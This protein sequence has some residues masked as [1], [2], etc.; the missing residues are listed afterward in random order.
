MADDPAAQTLDRYDVLMQL[1]DAY[2][3]TA[4]WPE[5]VE[6]EEAA[7]RAAQEI[8]DVELVSRA[9]CSATLGALWQSAPYGEVN[10]TVVAALRWCL[11]RLP[12]E[13]SP[14]RCRT[15]LGLANELYS[16]ATFEERLALIEEALAMAERLGDDELLLDANQVGFT[17]LWCSSTAERRL[18]FATRAAELAA[19]LGREQAYVVSTTLRAVV[20][21]ELGDIDQMWAAAA[22]ARAEAERL[23]IAFGIIVLDSL[24]LPWLAMA[25]R[26]DACEEVMDRIE[27]LAGQVSIENAGDA[28]AEAAISLRLWQGRGDEVIPLMEE[29]E[30]GPVPITALVVAYLIRTGHRERA[31][32][33]AAEHRIEL[34]GDSMAAMLSWCSSAEVA[35]ALDLPDLAAAAYTRLAP[36]AGRACGAG[37]SNAMGPVDAYLALAAAAVGDQELA[38]GHADRALELMAAWQI[39]LAAGWLTGERARY[40]F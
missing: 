26:F 37:S 27:R 5:L 21:A 13:D 38:R 20:A 8:G 4:R 2:R 9:A 12:A 18:R 29:M 25:G 11:E 10:A 28:L 33:H 14:G 17:A 32:R 39:P 24:T 3:W 34:P 16:G 40:G 23:R 1:V 35:C 36:Y 7:V 22:A 30:A 6:A 19:A 31:A 15:M